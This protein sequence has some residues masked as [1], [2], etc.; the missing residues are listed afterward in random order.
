MRLWNL[1]SHKMK[2]HC[3]PCLDEG[4]LLCIFKHTG[5]TTQKN[6]WSFN[7]NLKV[8]VLDRGRER[9][10]LQRIKGAKRGVSGGGGLLNK[11]VSESQLKRRTTPRCSLGG[12]GGRDWFFFSTVGPGVEGSSC[13]TELIWFYTLFAL[14]WFLLTPTPATAQCVLLWSRC[15]HSRKAHYHSGNRWQ[16][17]CCREGD[18]SGGD[19]LTD[20]STW[21]LML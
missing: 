12:G 9:P 6:S 4:L 1:E 19:L 13:L 11:P 14:V 17:C 16:S 18:W 21:L 7:L 15:A 3:L 20:C 2:T 8:L 5:T 10:T